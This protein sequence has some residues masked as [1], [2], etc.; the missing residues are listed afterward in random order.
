MN[1]YVVAGLVFAGAVVCG[2]L[3]TLIFDD[4]SWLQMAVISGAEL[5]AFSLGYYTRKNVGDVA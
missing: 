2:F 5:T 3:D 1:I 4:V